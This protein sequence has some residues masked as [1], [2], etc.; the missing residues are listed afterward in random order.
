MTGEKQESWPTFDLLV[1]NGCVIHSHSYEHNNS[2][3]ITPPEF[4]VL[5]NSMNMNVGVLY[6]YLHTGNANQSE[7]IDHAPNGANHASVP[8]LSCI[9]MIIIIIDYWYTVYCCARR[10]RRQAFKP[11]KQARDYMNGRNHKEV[12]NNV[13]CDTAGMYARWQPRI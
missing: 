9:I 13:C 1:E 6:A 3:I 5:E 2:S 11:S 8:N 10:A 7:I 12:K 4:L